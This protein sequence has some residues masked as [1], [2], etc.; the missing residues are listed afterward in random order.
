[1]RMI[2]FIGILSATLVWGCGGTVEAPAS[3]EMAA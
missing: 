1:M 3:P 2:A